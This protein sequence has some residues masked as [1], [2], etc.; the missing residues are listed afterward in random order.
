VEIEILK[1]E[2]KKDKNEGKK[3]E[4]VY[5]IKSLKH[6]LGEFL[7][8]G[9]KLLASEDLSDKEKN[10]LIDI[11][12]SAKG[13][14]KILGEMLEEKSDIDKGALKKIDKKADKFVEG[15]GLEEDKTEEE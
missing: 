8:E 6:N 7:E 13:A 5:G 12:A 14:G 11:M 15:L 1:G 4:C 10:Q 2:G 9:Y 3:M